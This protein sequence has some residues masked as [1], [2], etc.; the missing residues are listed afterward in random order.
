MPFVVQNPDGTFVGRRRLTQ[1][2]SPKPSRQSDLQ[3][4]TV[5]KRKEDCGVDHGAPGC[6]IREVRL[7]LVEDDAA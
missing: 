6:R 2:Q 1:Y 7:A 4:A 3:R 5:W